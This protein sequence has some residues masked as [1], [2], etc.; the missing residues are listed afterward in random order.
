MLGVFQFVWIDR[1][2]IVWVLC[3]RRGRAGIQEVWTAPASTPAAHLRSF[4]GGF[5]RISRSSSL[6]QIVLTVSVVIRLTSV[7]RKL[8]VFNCASPCV[9]SR[10]LLLLR[11]LISLLIQFLCLEWQTA[12]IPF[13]CL[14]ACSPAAISDKPHRSLNRS[15]TRPSLDPSWNHSKRSLSDRSFIIEYS[16]TNLT[17]PSLLRDNHRTGFS[18]DLPFNPL[19]LINRFSFHISVSLLLGST[20]C[21]SAILN[22]YLFLLCSAT[23]T[24][25]IIIDESSKE[26]L[27]V[28]NGKLFLDYSLSWN[29]FITETLSTKT[30]TIYGVVLAKEGITVYKANFFCVSIYSVFLSVLSLCM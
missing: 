25:M 15:P 29:W 5:W 18:V 11:S 30:L 21:V 7:W 27:W 6:H 19:L 8:S 2:F 12:N 13:S 26:N 22:R 23:N 14:P 4:R 10:T 20:L 28:R 3:F 17:T 24:N 16:W 9:I 1:Y